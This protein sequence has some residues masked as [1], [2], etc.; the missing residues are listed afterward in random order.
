MD[1][2]S[3]LVP[4]LPSLELDPTS[5]YQ[6]VT[7]LQETFIGA[8]LGTFIANLAAQTVRNIIGESDKDSVQNQ[9]Q[10]IIFQSQTSQ[11]QQD[12]DWRMIPAAG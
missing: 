4:A 5:K 12:T 2:L 1:F 8:F 10:N 7:L 11:D 9:T 3:S 6:N